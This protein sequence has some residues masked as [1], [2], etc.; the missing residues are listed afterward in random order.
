MASDD[1]LSPP[2]HLGTH[3][4]FSLKIIPPHVS[5]RASK[6]AH[7]TTLAPIFSRNSKLCLWVG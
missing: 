5:I 4:I 6:S 1:T 2:V 3:S 7:R